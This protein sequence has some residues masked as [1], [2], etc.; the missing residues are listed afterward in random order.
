MPHYHH[1]SAAAASSSSSSSDVEN[2][3]CDL[4]QDK[5]VSQAL[6]ERSSELPERIQSLIKECVSSSSLVEID[7]LKAEVK[8]K[9]E[10]IDRCTSPSPHGGTSWP[11]CLVLGLDRGEKAPLSALLVRVQ[12]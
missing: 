10:Q 3:H 1:S 12:A 5:I 9:Q 8:R 4:G 6:R 2:S 11:S 7:N